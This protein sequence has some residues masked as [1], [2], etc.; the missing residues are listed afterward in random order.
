MF[1]KSVEMNQLYETLLCSPGMKETVKVDVRISRKSILLLS[2]IIQKGLSE[3]G[4]QASEFATI[5]GAE[6]SSE[7][8]EMLKACLE[9][10]NLFELDERLAKL[11]EN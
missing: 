2:Q 9:K 11:R 3:S 6:S 7:L 1:M 8:Q 4:S 5:A 10:A